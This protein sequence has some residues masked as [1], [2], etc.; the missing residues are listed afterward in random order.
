MS[1]PLITAGITT[2]FLSKDIVNGIIRNTQI[3]I[4]PNGPTSPPTTQEV[5]A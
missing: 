4:A 3:H 5:V 1:A 2:S